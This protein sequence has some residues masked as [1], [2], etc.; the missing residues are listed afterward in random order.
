MGSRKN[1][2]ASRISWARVPRLSVPRATQDG[3]DAAIERVNH[4][5]DPLLD[6]SFGA[7]PHHASRWRNGVL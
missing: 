1:A 4:K 7:V 2:N 6:D 3:V 5:A